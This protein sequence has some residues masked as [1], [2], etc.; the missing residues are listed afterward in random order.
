MALAHVQS[1]K[2]TFS[3]SGGVGSLAYSSNV[4]A[5]NLL[6]AIPFWYSNA[7]VALTDS[8]N[9]A[10]GNATAISGG[11]GLDSASVQ[12]FFAIAGSS[13]ANTVTATFTG[14]TP[15]A[16]SFALFEFSGNATASP[17]QD[18]SGAT[19]NALST[20][21]TTAQANSMV[22]GGAISN[23]DLSVG[24]GYTLGPA[25]DTF[26]FEDEEYNLDAGSAGSKTVDFGG[27]GG[28]NRIAAAAFKVFTASTANRSLPTLGTGIYQPIIGGG[29]FS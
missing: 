24:S 23:G 18:G 10:W 15:A 17:Q 26:W 11:S 16:Q 7:T 8:Q 5:N 20:S 4:V 28:T 12:I 2:S 14:T 6:I 27:A 22:I 25:L 9:N 19:A 29:L 3:L 13:T 21:V 1:R